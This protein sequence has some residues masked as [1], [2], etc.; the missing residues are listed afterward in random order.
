VHTA[1]AHDLAFLTPGLVHQFGNLLFTIQGHALH[2]APIELA[3]ARTAIGGACERGGASLR[4]VRHLLGGGPP[5][6]G[7]AA[8]AVVQLGELLRIPVRDSGH[9]LE[10]DETHADAAVQ[11]DLAWFSA[12]VVGAVRSL[13]HAAPAG[14]RGVLTLAVRREPARLQLALRQGAGDLPFP[15]AIDDTARQVTAHAARL[16][17]AVVLRRRTDGIEI[18]LPEAAGV[19]EA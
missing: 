9:V 6:R 15:L 17:S 8:P 3:R 7:A 1:T 2:G 18:L 5:E 19:A 4:L 14:M 16:G 12:L 10:I 13:L 11:V